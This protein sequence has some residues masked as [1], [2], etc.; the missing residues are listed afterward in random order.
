MPDTREELMR[1]RLEMVRDRLISSEVLF[2]YLSL[3]MPEIAAASGIS[4]V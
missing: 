3:K 4:L 2:F 1:Y